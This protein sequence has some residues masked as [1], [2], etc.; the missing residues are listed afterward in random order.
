MHETSKQLIAETRM[1][2]TAKPG[3]PAGSRHVRVTDRHAA[4]DYAQVFKELPD[5]HF[6]NAEKI[7]LVQDNLSTHKPASLYEASAPPAGTIGMASRSRAGANTKSGT[8]P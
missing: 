6:P 3:R 5:T 8:A 4:V 7:V 2:I 1:P